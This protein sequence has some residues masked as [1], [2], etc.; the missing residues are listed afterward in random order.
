MEDPER[1][2]RGTVR[3]LQM[4]LIG[5]LLMTFAI[6]YDPGDV[7]AGVPARVTTRPVDWSGR[8][9]WEVIVNGQVV[10][11]M[12]SSWGGFPARERATIIAER[13]RKLLSEQ[14]DS[15]KC[16]R[17]L[18]VD[19]ER[20][21]I[22][23]ATGDT[24]IVTVDPIVAQLNHSSMWS[25]AGIWANNIRKALGLPSEFWPTETVQPNRT[26]VT[27]GVASWYGPGFHGE[28]TAGGEVFDQ[29]ALTAAHRSLPFGSRVKVT[30][31]D[32][33]RSV[34]VRINDRGPWVSGRVID[35]SR[36]AAESIG[37]IGK[38]IAKV[39]LETITEG[40]G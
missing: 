30:N 2:C 32:N 1:R 34:I 27:Y 18:E 26:A 20:Q 25:L 21:I 16:V 31:L 15:C 24:P 23:V 4:L 17:P 39:K 3:G 8:E 37:L 22:A 7:A 10:I 12:R 29:Y 38:G 40:G 19:R 11:R 36:R 35:L 5:G 33:G 9:I 28:T 14:V 6:G 13:L